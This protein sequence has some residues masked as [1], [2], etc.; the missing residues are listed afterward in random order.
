MMM[1]VFMFRVSLVKRQRGEAGIILRQV[2]QL[3][4]G[5]YWCT[6]EIIPQATIVSRSKTLTIKGNNNSHHHH[7][8]HRCRRR[9]HHHHQLLK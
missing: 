6:I 5:Q 9:C 1:M 2:S 4:T 7:H 3:D 8:C